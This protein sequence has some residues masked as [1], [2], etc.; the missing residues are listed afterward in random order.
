MGIDFATRYAAVDV[1]LSLRP[2]ESRGSDAQAMAR[3]VRIVLGV[4]AA[5]QRDAPLV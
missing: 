5:E 4:D 2:R 1:L 3:E